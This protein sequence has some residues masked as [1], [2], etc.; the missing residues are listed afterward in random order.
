MDDLQLSNP[1][2]IEEREM[3]L[4]GS[5]VL[6]YYR[7]QMKIYLADTARFKASLHKADQEMQADIAGR[8]MDTYFGR[9]IDP[10]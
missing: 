4:T 3:K 6:A 10:K 9:D 1:N 5:H 2:N 8:I 7:H